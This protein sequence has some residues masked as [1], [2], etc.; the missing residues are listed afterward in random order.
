MFGPQLDS[1]GATFRLWAPAATSV[2]LVIGDAY[3][4]RRHNDGWFDLRVPGTG[5]GARYMFRIDG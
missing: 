5:A 4:M 2:D 1:K 3:P